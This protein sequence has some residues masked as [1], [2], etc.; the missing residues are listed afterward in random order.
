[1]SLT[2]IFILLNLKILLKYLLL[3]GALMDINKLEF[4][5]LMHSMKRKKHIQ[6][7]Q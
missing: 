2:V 7:L 4:L 1:M 3:I 5:V 6:I